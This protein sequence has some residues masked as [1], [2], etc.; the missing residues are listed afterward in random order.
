MTITPAP[1]CADGSMKPGQ[2]LGNGV[3]EAAA[4][5]EP[6]TSDVAQ[7]EEVEDTIA[8]VWEAVLASSDFGYDDRFLDVG[9]SSMLVPVVYDRLCVEYP[10]CPIKVIDLFR[11]PTIAALAKVLHERM[12]GR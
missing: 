5:G 3:L 9:G 2:D 1:Y 8:A 4:L 12:A 7:I 10:N 6:S 11:Q